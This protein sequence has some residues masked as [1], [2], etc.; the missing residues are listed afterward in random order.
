MPTVSTD[1]LVDVE[2]TVKVLRVELVI[3]TLTASVD[4]HVS[5][6]AF[7]FGLVCGD[8][9]SSPPVPHQG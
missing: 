5:T 7:Y 9:S 2:P 1:P 6:I 4:Q 8:D 3:L